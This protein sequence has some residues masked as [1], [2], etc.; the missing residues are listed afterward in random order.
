MATITIDHRATRKY[1]LWAVALFALINLIAAAMRHLS[2][3]MPSLR[4]EFS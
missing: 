2:T 3:R 1:L 4:I